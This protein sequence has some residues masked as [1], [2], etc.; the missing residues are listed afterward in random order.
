MMLLEP[1]LQAYLMTAALLFVAGVLCMATKRNAIGVLM[2][3]EMVLT[4]ANFNLVA[5]ARYGKLGIDGHIFA[6]FVIVLAAGEAAIALAIALNFYN[7]FA[8]IDVD[9]ADNLKG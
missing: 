1:T 9:R 4:A 7:N 6:L 5:F 2:G 3:V 8:T